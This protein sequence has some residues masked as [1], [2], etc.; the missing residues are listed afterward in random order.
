MRENGIHIQAATVAEPT[1]Q[2]DKEWGLG[3]TTGTHMTKRTCIGSRRDGRTRTNGW[4]CVEIR[5]STDGHAYT[6]ACTTQTHTHNKHTQSAHTK[7]T[8]QTHAHKHAQVREAQQPATKTDGRPTSSPSKL[9][10]K[11]W[12]TQVPVGAKG[13][14]GALSLSST[15]TIGSSF[16]SGAPSRICTRGWDAGGNENESAVQ[17]ARTSRRIFQHTHYPDTHT[18]HKHIHMDHTHTRTTHEPHKLS[19]R[20]IHTNSTHQAHTLSTHTKHTQIQQRSMSSVNA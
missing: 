2:A 7:H 1:S 8:K 14:I 20:K 15:K 13:M 19:K 4:E 5:G 3:E 9:S 10:T 12:R 18:K 11:V 6:C 16:S 17:E